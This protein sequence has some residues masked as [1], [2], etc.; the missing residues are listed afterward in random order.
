[1]L[2]GS[3]TMM[4]TRHKI[5]QDAYYLKCDGKK[6]FC[7]VADGMGGHNAGDV[8]SKTVI[9]FIAAVDRPTKENIVETIKNANGAVLGMS[10]CD[11]SLEGMGT[12]V[13]GAV[14]NKDNGFIFHIGD[15]RAYGINRNYVKQLTID[16]SYVQELVDNGKITRA[17]AENHPMKNI[18]TMAIGVNDEIN[19]AIKEITFG[20]DEIL[21]LC[22]DGVS[23]AV[24]EE[25]MRTCCFEYMPAQA[26]EELCRLAVKNGASDD[27]TAIVVRID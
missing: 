14:I 24:T 26:A 16:H 6:C 18:I 9:D 8:A 5:N 11:K 13:V 27:V 23:G 2:A 12:T 4:G 20:K 21:L 17:E 15:S 19:P 7:V 1:M 22:S 25:E 3:Y 10:S